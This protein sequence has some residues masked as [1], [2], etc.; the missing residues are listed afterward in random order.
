MLL[1]RQ[2]DDQGR[3]TGVLVKHTGTTPEQNFSDRFVEAALADGWAVLSGDKLTLKADPEPLRYTVRRQPGYFCK[4]TG[5]PIPLSADAWLRFRLGG[6]SARSQAEARAWLAQK[7]LEANDY[8]ITTAYHCVLDAGLHA[9]Y[10]AVSAGGIAR[11]A[12][13]AEV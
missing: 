7:G 5:E 10:R 8:D 12:V 9:K 11:Q 13:E 4:S 3:C 6:N 2:L 1:K